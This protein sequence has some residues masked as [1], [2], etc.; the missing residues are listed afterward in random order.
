[1]GQCSSG[2]PQI[3]AGTQ[4]LTGKGMGDGPKGAALNTSLTVS[5]PQVT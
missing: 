2:L 1:M 3:P 5:C 4:T